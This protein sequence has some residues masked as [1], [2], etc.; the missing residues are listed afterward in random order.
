VRVVSGGAGFRVSA[1]AR[2]VAAAS[3]GQIVQVR[4]AGGQQVSGVAKAG[5]LVEVAF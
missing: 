5:G 1:E 2:A 4:T 3:E